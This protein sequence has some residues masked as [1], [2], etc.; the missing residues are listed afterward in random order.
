MQQDILRDT[1]VYQY[2]MKEGIE[3]GIE[4]GEQ[5][6]VE[7][8]RLEEARELLF[9]FV[10][11]RF[12]KLENLAKRETMH[13]QDAKVL[14]DLTLKVGLAKDSDEARKHLTSWDEV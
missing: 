11:A 12:P 10:H 7:K 4:Q 5:R 14:H 3:Q 6:G 13:I 2:I 1:P 9:S 8:G